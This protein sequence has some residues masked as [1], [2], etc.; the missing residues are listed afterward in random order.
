MSFL[1]CHHYQ[2]DCLQGKKEYTPPPWD[3]SFLGLSPD[4]EVTEQKKLW[5]IPFSWENKEKGIHH[6]SGKRGI[7]HRASDPEK[8]KK[9]GLHG[10]GVYFFLP[11]ASTRRL[12]PT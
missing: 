12:G 5:C 1:Q 10:G 2:Q 8:E 11:C 9:G 6:R 4:P 3:P 7:H